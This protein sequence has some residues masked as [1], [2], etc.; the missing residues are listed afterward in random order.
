MKEKII[1]IIENCSPTF[2]PIRQKD[3]FNIADLIVSYLAKEGYGK[4]GYIEFPTL[5]GDGVFQDYRFI[6][7]KKEK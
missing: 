3:I 6:P 4:M 7:I 2:I 1:E 5:S